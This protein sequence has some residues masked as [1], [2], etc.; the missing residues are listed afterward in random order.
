MKKMK[1]LDS[2]TWL[3]RTAQTHG[4]CDYDFVIKVK[5]S[6]HKGLYKVDIRYESNSDI[7]GGT[8]MSFEE[9]AEKVKHGNQFGSGNALPIAFNLKDAEKVAQAIASTYC[10]VGR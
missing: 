4:M 5:P 7:F 8:P 6:Y 2:K 1:K 3:I 10:Y 9:V